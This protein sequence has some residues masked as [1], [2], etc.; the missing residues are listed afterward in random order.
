M[1]H[2]RQGGVL[3]SCAFAVYPVYFLCIAFGFVA[4]R[5]EAGTDGLVFFLNLC[6]ISDF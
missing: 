6:S 4:K 1:Y 3:S 5:S 2:V